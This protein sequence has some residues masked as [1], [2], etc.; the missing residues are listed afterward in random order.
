MLLAQLTLF[1]VSLVANTLS[2]L[3]GGGLGLLQLP[4][5]LFLG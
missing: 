2:A 3:A 5:L 4:A 1:F